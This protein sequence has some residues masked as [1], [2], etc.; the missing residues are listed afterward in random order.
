MKVVTSLQKIYKQYKK[1]IKKFYSKQKSTYNVYGNGL[2]SVFVLFVLCNPTVG[3]VAYRTQK[4]NFQNPVQ[5]IVIKKAT[6]VSTCILE[7]EVSLLSNF[8][9]DSLTLRETRLSSAHHPPCSH[10]TK[11]QPLSLGS[12]LQRLA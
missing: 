4:N 9:C 8:K 5:N 2:P 12:T 6:I 1:I 11:T 7:F 3:S 10:H